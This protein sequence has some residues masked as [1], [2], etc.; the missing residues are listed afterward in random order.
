M[1]TTKGEFRRKQTDDGT[2]NAKELEGGSEIHRTGHGVGAEYF[3][4]DSKGRYLG[5]HADQQQAELMAIKGHPNVMDDAPELSL[6]VMWTDA[7]NF[8]TKPLEDV[9]NKTQFISLG[10]KVVMRAQRGEHG[11]DVSL[12]SEAD[13]WEQYQ[14]AGT[15]MLEL[16]IADEPFI[17]E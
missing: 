14:L 11:W 7:V 10:H 6:W 9:E 8:G 5:F 4:H 3:A 16:T 17:L 15:D 12:L 2:I 13:F 1:T